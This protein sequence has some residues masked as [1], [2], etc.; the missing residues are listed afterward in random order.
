[1]KHFWGKL[2]HYLLTGITFSF[3]AGIVLFHF[4]PFTPSD[5][6]L[7]SLLLAPPILFYLNRKT[8]TFF[9]TGLLL[10]TLIIAFLHASVSEE[11]GSQNSSISTKITKEEDAVLIGTL[12]SMPLFDGKKSTVII[13]S[14]HI[15][16]KNEELISSTQG[17]VQLRL[18]DEWPSAIMPGDELVIRTRLSRP[19][20]FGNPGGFDYPA[21]LKANNID[22]VG[23]ISS[24]AHIHM[25][26]HKT[27][28]L[29]TIKYLPERI[30]LS[31]K[32]EIN[33]TFTPQKAGLYRALL[34]GDRSGLSQ[35]QLEAFKASGVFH[36]LA[37]SGLHLSI[38]ASFL[39]L[40][41]YWLARRSKF[42]L[43]AIS[44]KKLALLATIP[45]LCCYA[46]L[47]GFQ[48]PVQRSLIM[49]LLFIFSFCVQRKP[50][51]FITLS[52]A[53]LIILLL[54]PSALF[55]A[56]FQLS[57]AAVA[58]LIL[59][60]PQLKAILQNKDMEDSTGFR[61]YATVFKQWITAGLLVSVVA[62]IGTAPL[63]LSNFNR[64]STVGPFANLLLEP[65]L[66]LWSLPIGL[67]ASF[68]LFINQPIGIWLLHLGGIG[69]TGAESVTTILA[70]LNFASLWLATPSVTL[71]IFYYL[72]LSFCFLKL[73][74][75][76]TLPIFLTAC[77]LFLIPL[78]SL[79]EKYSTESELVFLDVG[80]GSSTLL[81]FPGGKTI[82]IDGGGSSS[83]KF[84]V[85]ES[86]IAPYLWHKG[87]TRLDAIVITHPDSDHF[88][89]IPFI[90]KRFKPDILWT[91]GNDG[92][93]QGYDDLLS[94][95]KDLGIQI[96][97]PQNNQILLESKDAFLQNIS[98]PYLDRDKNL[99]NNSR[100]PSNDESLILKYTGANKKLSCLFP[101]DI[102]K[103]IELALV[104]NHNSSRLQSSFLLSP[105]HGSKT[106]NSAIFLNKINPEQIIVSAGRFRPQHFPSSVLKL[107][108]KENDIPLLN[109]AESGAIRIKAEGKKVN[110][111]HFW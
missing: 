95:A 49:V 69:I 62:T 107:Y 58:S 9:V 52:F 45:P 84:N 34:I 72:S 74:L 38:V 102:T 97:K 50:T 2:N 53:A 31:I 44:C 29:H 46:L 33:K 27:S 5:Q 14:T 57:F 66:C 104:Q 51:P 43:L 70:N 48:T 39:F 26:D 89:G 111:T 3:I 59:I 65:L 106:S 25:L 17:L 47:A 63:L 103:A 19:Y 55:T 83:E 79:T 64:I 86:I 8:Q 75:K 110:I 1:M 68:M 20:R 28:W 96:K 98:N 61:H 92:H 105:H 30:R 71:I 56:S 67:L 88:N 41:F 101:G 93:E 76:K 54:N 12:K 18:K 23:R 40:I 6:T 109:T 60:L 73:P 87:I 7:F 36:V 100:I 13:K 15:R 85:G 90:L 42:L 99:V 11:M 32:D 81:N 16:L 80:Q 24:T 4:I 35:A 77:I 10:F 21:F 108:C 82:L 78:K 22:I 94:L 91:N 37:I